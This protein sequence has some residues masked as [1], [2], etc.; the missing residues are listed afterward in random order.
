MNQK[1]RYTAQRMEEVCDD[2]GE[3]LFGVLPSVS[4]QGMELV[5]LWEY[6]VLMMPKL[7]V[8]KYEVNSDKF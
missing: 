5:P 2:V 6:H 8:N 1:N 7:A 4:V 3:K